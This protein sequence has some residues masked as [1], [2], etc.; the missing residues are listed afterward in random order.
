MTIKLTIYV[1][2][3]N[4]VEKLKNCLAMIAREMPGCEDSV[5]VIVSNNCST[6]S[7]RS[8]LESLSF[9]WLQLQHNERNI[10]ANANITKCFSLPF[11]TEFIWA[12]GDDDYLMPGAISGLLGL[13]AQFPDADYIFCNSKAY[14][15]EKSAE[16]MQTFLESG[17][18]EGGDV[19]SRKYV[20]TA[21]I[22][23]EKMI[24][25]S[26]ADTLLGELM[27]NC[28]RQS[29]VR[30]VDE[31]TV[32]D[33]AQI[34]WDSTDLDAMGR[35]YQSHNVPLLQSFNAK[36]RAVYCDVVRT[37]N[38][39]GSAEWLNNYD[40]VFPVII[41]Y[42]IKQYKLRGFISEDKF[43]E[44]LHYYYRV[45]RNSLARQATGTSKARAFNDRIKA[46]MFDMACLYMNRRPNMAA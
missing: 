6:D 18:I 20:G 42:L 38:F 5:V 2:T 33:T 15:T 41:L 27:C 34:D 37:F 1:P 40:Y 22:E 19:K 13:I 25:P 45:M 36:T 43:F 16:V 31:G 7:T 26:I 30:F 23:F 29:A 9:P 4:R 24:D 44:L 35:L 10:G 32:W 39:W 11:Q 46:E 21:L 28:F 17:L 3:Y 12:I 14:P 8:Y